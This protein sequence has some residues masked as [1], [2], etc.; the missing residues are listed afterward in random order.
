MAKLKAAGAIVLGKTNVTEL[1]GIFDSNLPEGYSS[2][3][4]QV[5]LPSDTDK[6]PAGSS[7]GSAAATASGLAALTVGSETSTDSAQMIAP[8][9]VAGVVAL[10]PTV[11][12]VSRA[13]VMPVARTQDSPG[14][15]ARTV[16]DAALAL[17]AMDD[18]SADYL[19][20]LSPDALSGKR[21]AVISNTTAPYPAAVSA[22]QALGAVTE[23]KT[24]GTPS[25]NPPSIVARE[26]ERDLDDYLSGVSGGAG[27][28]EAIIAYNEANPVE[29]LKYQQREL[30]EA[31]AADLSAYEED[32]AA[33]LASNRALIDALLDGFDVA[34][35]PSGNALVGIADRAGYPVLTVPA[36]YG[37]GGAGRNPIG[38]TFVGV[39]GSEA[40][41]L[42]AG[43]AYEQATKVRLAPSWTNPSMWRCVPGSTFYSPHHCHPGDLESDTA[44]GPTETPVAVDVGGTVPATLAL[45]VSGPISFGAFTPGLPKTYL[46]SALGTVTST[47]GEAALTVSDPSSTA[48]GRLVNGAF[49]LPQAL[50]AAAG[51]PF[52]EVGG[53]GSPTPLLSYSGPV[54]NDAVTL[55]FQQPIGANDG[56]RTGTYRKTLVFTLSTTQP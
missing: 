54:S 13:G 46:A 27:S 6:T 1:G 50:K 7:A 33:G 17:Q 35:V 42:A 38:V 3:G 12:L 36:G 47:A 4:G 10:K 11:G 39:A 5:L 18:G 32:R 34:M 8:A 23:V 28:L 44:Q 29:G 24:V 51:G 41:L 37:T 19:A 43:Y 45:S 16:Y 56:L 21:V 30:V 26:L 53:S 49:A 22:I 31:A 48:T 52:A 40:K 55:S 9:G 14:P 15:I 2:L 20:G 25:P